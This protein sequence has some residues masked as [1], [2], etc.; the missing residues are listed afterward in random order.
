MLINFIIEF[1][2]QYLFSMRLYLSDFGDKTQEIWIFL[3]LYKKAK[4]CTDLVVKQNYRKT[5]LL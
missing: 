4:V 1:L 5:D 2:L 3:V